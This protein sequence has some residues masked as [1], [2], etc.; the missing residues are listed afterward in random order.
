ME[1]TKKQIKKANASLSIILGVLVLALSVRFTYYIFTIFLLLAFIPTIIFSLLNFSGFN[2]FTIISLIK[3]LICS[4]CGICVFLV[5]PYLGLFST[6]TGS[7]AIIGLLIE[8]RFTDDKNHLANGFWNIVIS[9]VLIVMGLFS[10]TN[11]NLTIVKYVLGGLIV[12]TAIIV[13]YLLK[14][15]KQDVDQILADYER[16]YQETH[17][18]EIDNEKI[19]DSTATEEP[20]D[21]HEI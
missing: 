5:K 2:R 19:I 14:E 4:I 16:R 13:Y 10:Y 21:N 11:L 15:P 3:C 7:I 8:S 6:L 9:I 1:L 20:T 12:I 18:E 17:Q